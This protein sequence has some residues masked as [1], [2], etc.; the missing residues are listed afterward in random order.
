MNDSGCWAR[1]WLVDLV[2]HD[3]PR[4]LTLHDQHCVRLQP[5]KLREQLRELRRPVAH[6]VPK[7]GRYAVVYEHSWGGQ[8]AVWMEAAEYVYGMFGARFV[9]VQLVRPGALGELVAVGDPVELTDGRLAELPARGG[10]SVR[11]A[12]GSG[13]AW[14]RRGWAGRPRVGA[15]EGVLLRAG[16]GRRLLLRRIAG[17]PGAVVSAAWIGVLLVGVLSALA[18]T[19]GDDTAARSPHPGRNA[20]RVVPS[21]MT[22]ATAPNSVPSAPA[23]PAS[24][25]GD[26]G[27][28]V[29]ISRPSCDGAYGVFVGAAVRPGAYQREV[30]D[31]LARYSGASYLLAEQACP[32]L[33][34]R[35]GA[36]NSIYAVYYGPFPTLG[37]ACETKG[38]VGVGSYVRRLDNS[39]SR[40]R[41][42]AC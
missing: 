25:S 26:L 23:R 32:S 8:E 16:A 42:I 36:G 13:V 15:G 41:T 12:V 33:R 20:A 37:N 24:A 35:T 11:E 7:H 28:A 10:T 19:G 39:G 4:P 17:A 2:G 29:P 18:L 21:P 3:T 9:F 14:L 5:T 40:S 34:P 27:L 22:A 1:S 31:F 6:G 38:R 30:G